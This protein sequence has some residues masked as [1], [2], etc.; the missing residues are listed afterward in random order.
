MQLSNITP[1]AKWFTDTDKWLEFTVYKRDGSIQDISLFTAFTWGLWKKGS[2]TA[3]PLIF[4]TMVDAE[5]E[6]SDGPGGKFLVEI[7]RA[8]THPTNPEV[9][10]GS[11]YQHFGRATD[12]DGVNDY[13][14]YG[15]VTLLQGPQVPA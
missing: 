3:A 8:D 13:I 9:P 15:D 6:I 14:V 2:V 5:I 11:D 7:V 12:A 1:A 4:K 10:G